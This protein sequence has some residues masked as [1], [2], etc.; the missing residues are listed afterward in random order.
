MKTYDFSDDVCEAYIIGSIRGGW[1]S[2]HRFIANRIFGDDLNQLLTEPEKKLNDAYESTLRDRFNY[3]NYPD[4]FL[5]VETGQTYTAEAIKMRR[6]LFCVGDS[7][8]GHFNKEKTV[9]ILT[10]L[11]D[12]LKEKDCYLFLVRGGNDDPSYFSEEGLGLSNII[13]LPDYSVV[14]IIYGPKLTKTNILCVGGETSLLNSAFKKLET[15]ARRVPGQED[16]KM[17][18]KDTGFH[19]DQS[20]VDKLKDMDI[21]LL[22]TS[23]CFKDPNDNLGGFGQ[24]MGTVGQLQ[25]ENEDICKLINK[26]TLPSLN[27]WFTAANANYMANP[28]KCSDEESEV[29]KPTRMADRFTNF[30]MPQFYGGEKG[31][32]YKKEVDTRESTRRLKISTDKLYE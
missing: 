28:P 6:L 9:R 22:L 29:P 10:P 30:F 18:W 20:E 14:T 23:T 8:L 31:V 17:T 26:E 19:F 1:S 11:N 2:F 25:K 4:T 3:P 5:S 27:E 15:I 24:I 21:E 32:F 12:Y 7:Y 13:P 16:V